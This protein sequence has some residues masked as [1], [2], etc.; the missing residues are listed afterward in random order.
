MVFGQRSCYRAD[1][2]GNDSPGPL[3]GCA[4]AL[5]VSLPL[6]DVWDVSLPRAHKGLLIR[7]WRGTLSLTF[8]LIPV[9]PRDVHALYYLPLE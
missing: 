1:F 5:R 2:G 9:V 3:P 8:S 4:L 6:A 7:D